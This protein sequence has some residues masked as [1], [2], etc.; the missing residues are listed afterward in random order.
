LYLAHVEQSEGESDGLQFLVDVDEEIEEFEV[1]VVGLESEFYVHVSVVGQLAGVYFLSVGPGEYFDA[2]AVLELRHVDG[3]D[4]N[5][6]VAEVVEGEVEEEL[7]LF[8]DSR[9]N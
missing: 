4:K 3:I 1:E 6:A 5:R 7:A 2:V 9:F 8:Y